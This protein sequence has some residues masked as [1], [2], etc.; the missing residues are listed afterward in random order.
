[1]HAL[2]DRFSKVIKASFDD[3]V[4]QFREAMQGAFGPLDWLPEA[5]GKIHR[6]NVPYDPSSSKN[7]WYVMFSDGIPAGVFGSWKT[8]MT[9]KWLSHN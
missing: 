1:M 8:G 5:D 2:E 6:F 9:G 3:A 4:L 7:G